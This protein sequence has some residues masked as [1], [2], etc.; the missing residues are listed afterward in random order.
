MEEWQEGKQEKVYSDFF[1]TINDLL[2]V[3]GRFYMQTMTFSKNMVPFEELD[4]NAE[5]GSTAYI[6]A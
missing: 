4:V 1:K 5:K 3:G 6:M 2:P